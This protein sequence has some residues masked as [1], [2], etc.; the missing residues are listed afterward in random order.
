MLSLCSNWRL[1]FSQTKWR[2]HQSAEFQ[3]PSTELNTNGDFGGVV[4]KMGYLLAKLMTFRRIAR[5][6]ML[7]F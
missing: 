2:R 5:L 4:V 1:A 3:V 6:L 7:R